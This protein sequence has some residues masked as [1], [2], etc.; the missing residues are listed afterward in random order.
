LEEVYQQTQN[1]NDLVSFG[2]M[3]V[4]NT[5]RCY[6]CAAKLQIFIAHVLGV[7]ISQF[8]L[9][10]LLQMF[11]AKKVVEEVATGKGLIHGSN[12]TQ[13]V[14]KVARTLF[15]GIPVQLC[16]MDLAVSILI[17]SAAL[18]T[19]DMVLKNYAADSG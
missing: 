14:K 5:R 17:C 9:N 11:L 12:C 8:L 18:V 4:G 2:T 13:Q 3:S 19:P 16:T 6:P 10:I 1:D 15:F 7:L